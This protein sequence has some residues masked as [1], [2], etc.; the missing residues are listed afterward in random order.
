MG[1]LPDGHP[2]DH[3]A[4]LRAAPLLLSAALTALARPAGTL[5][6]P[7]PGPA[8]R[9]PLAPVAGVG[10]PT[11]DRCVSC[12]E[13]IAAEWRGSLHHRSWQNAY[14]VKSYAAEPTAFCRKCHAPSADPS[15]PPPPEARELG[16]GCTTCH[17]V[18]AGI[19]GTRGLPRGP[20]GHEVIGDPRLGSSLAC[21]GC[22]DFPFPSL[23]GQKAGPMQD[24]L[25]EH[26]RSAHASTPCQGCHMPAVPSRGGGTHR[27]HGFMVQG[28]KA[29]LARAVVVKVALLGPGEVRIMLEPGA[30]GHAFPT[31]DLFR[32]VEVRSIP[33]DVAGRP[34]PGGSREILGRTFATPR[35]AQEVLPREQTGDTR[36]R[37]QRILSLPVPRETR[38][39]RWQIVWQ[40]MPPAIAAR[41]GMVMREQEV[42]VAEGVVTR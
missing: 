13:E 25:G 41:L 40:R 39:A 4:G 6:L 20:N 27:A 31:G 18:P 29:M 3:E 32:Q 26:R 10:L 28:D 21:G 2:Q 22:H 16:I 34:L 30:V 1:G 19:V 15:A 5:D 12:H 7:L 42:V 23:P 37:G 8:P 11:D 24:T 36:L 35:I 33:L 17:V 38:Q 14:F 9:A